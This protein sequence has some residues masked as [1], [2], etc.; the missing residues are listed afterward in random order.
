MKKI[1]LIIVGVG[2]LMFCMVSVSQAALIDRGGGLIY[3]DVLKITWLQDANYA[4]TSSY[5]SDGLMNWQEANNW[6]LTLSYYDS[7][8]NQTLTGWRLP[9]T[10][11]GP[12]VSGY[13]GT[14]TAG[15]N[16]FSS[17]MGYMYYINLENKG[18][19]ASNGTYPQ[20]GY[21]LNNTSYFYNIQ[22]Y[23]YWSS[24]EYANNPYYD[25][26][27]I[28]ADGRQFAYANHYNFD[29][30]AVRDGDVGPGPIAPVPEPATLSLF[31]FGL[32][33]LVFKRKNKLA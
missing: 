29:A 12:Y 13:D 32:L 21:G 4:Y 27:F 3:D 11:D 26:G 18:Y 9:T 23:Y 1:I 22:P 28:M 24:T 14:T 2:L 31:C 15:Y 7:V 17:E 8:R 30:W 16:L 33:G 25:W 20:P 19:Y 10:V 6:A 5:D